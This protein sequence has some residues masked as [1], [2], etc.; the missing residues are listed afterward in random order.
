MEFNEGV[1]FDMRLRLKVF[2]ACLF[3][4]AFISHATPAHGATAYCMANPAVPICSSGD[5]DG[6]YGI[7]H[8]MLPLQQ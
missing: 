4:L 7:M 3:A 5:S 1:L 6:E 2:V 8:L